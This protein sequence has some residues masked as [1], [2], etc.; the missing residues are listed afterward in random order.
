MSADRLKNLFKPTVINASAYQVPDASD[1]IKLDAMENPYIWPANLKQAWCDV[2]AKVEVNRYPDATATEM[3]TVLQTILDIPDSMQMLF[4]NGSDEL[5]QILLLALKPGSGLV[6][7]PEP[8]FVMYR[9]IANVI[10]LPFQGVPLSTGFDLDRAAML[11]A[12]KQHR[13][14]IVFLARPNN[15]TGNLFD[16]DTIEE[17]IQAAPGLVVI[18]EAYHAF[19]GQT[20]MPL[21]QQYD[22]LL[23]LRTL[24]KLGLAGLRLGVLVGQETWLSQ[25]EKI[26]LPYNIGSLNQAT[27]TFI[28]KHINVLQDQA[29]ILIEQREKLYTSLNQLNSVKVWP[30]KANFLLFKSQQR[31]AAD[32]H[33]GLKQRNILIKNLD[34]SH[35]QLT[36]CLRVTVGT[37]R[38]NACFLQALQEIL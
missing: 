10:G 4:G 8:T 36:G 9:V 28:G 18:D 7:A 35:P 34:G 3:N 21:L 5:I 15:P 23:L 11:A 22:H 27:M 33:Q 20:L 31:S 16:T 32:V 13:P 12:I 26:R 1:M 17:I 37:E 6:L 38:E 2:L 29:H 24:S 25:L 14:G 30:S 19:S